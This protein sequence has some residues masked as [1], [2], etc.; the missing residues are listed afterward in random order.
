MIPLQRERESSLSPEKLNELAATLAW[1]CETYGDSAG[2]S[3]SFGGPGGLVLAHAAY[4]KG[5]QIPILFI[6]TDFLFPETYALKEKLEKEW[7]LRI[8]TASPSLTPEEQAEQFGEGLWSIDPDRCCYLRKVEP[9]ARLLDGIDCWVTALR[10]DQSQSRAKL[11]RFEVHVTEAGT[12]ILKVNPLVDWT[13]SDVWT[14]ILENNVPYN[15]L[16]D[17]G[18]AS[19]GCTHCTAMTVGDDERSGR[20][21]GTSKTECGLH[22]F[23]RRHALP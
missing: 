17:R 13:R 7:A 14:Y 9:M 15:P 23:T 22:T 18:Y 6:D 11:E 1:V 12:T 2:L 20:W 3:C 10:R 4:S 21:A 5:L 16:L 8:R 19:L